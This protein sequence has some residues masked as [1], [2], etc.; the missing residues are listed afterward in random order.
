MIAATV[1]PGSTYRADT[2]VRRIATELAEDPLG[3]HWVPDPL[4][5]EVLERVWR[6]HLGYAG[7]H[8]HVHV[9]N[10]LDEHALACRDLCGVAVWLPHTR[11]HPKPPDY[12]QRLAEAAGPYADQFLGAEELLAE[13][14]PAATHH[15]LVALAVCPLDEDHSLEGSLLDHHH[16]VLDDEGIAAYL[17]TTDPQFRDRCQLL[18]YRLHDMATLPGLSDPL[19]RMWRPADDRADDMT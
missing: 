9:I 13:Q 11:W 19:W 8:G 12:R 10:G 3:A 16:E 2:I 6:V 1:Q 7:A 18:G 5:I 17:D 14:R 4:R 15:Y